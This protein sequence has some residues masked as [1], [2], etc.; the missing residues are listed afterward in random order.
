MMSYEEFEKEIKEKI[1]ELLAKI[2]VE[3]SNRD[4]LK[5]ERS[6][7]NSKIEDYKLQLNDLNDSKS[8]MLKHRHESLINI[9]AG[10]PS[11]IVLLIP[12]IIIKLISNDIGIEILKSI[13]QLISIVPCCVITGIAI[14]PIARIL[15]DK[16]K[17]R[18]LKR[19]L[20]RLSNNREFQQLLSQ[21]ETVES[22]KRSQ[23]TLFNQKTREI[24]AINRNINTYSNDISQLR[25]FLNFV[26]SKIKPKETTLT[27][28]RTKEKEEQ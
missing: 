4:S 17:D 9:I 1:D 8:D 11:A 26:T 3:E 14:C 7:I 22:S 24:S 12:F 2:K 5:L 20:E 28:T 16:I 25:G 13:F 23:E 21:I 15:F 27:R 6:Q 19:H 10:I 18:L